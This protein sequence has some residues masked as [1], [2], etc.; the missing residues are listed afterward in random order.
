MFLKVHHPSLGD[1]GRMRIEATNTQLS[2]FPS[3]YN[4]P[5]ATSIP[6]SYYCRVPEQSFGI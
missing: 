6:K 2:R 1:R 4:V 3:R 5:Q